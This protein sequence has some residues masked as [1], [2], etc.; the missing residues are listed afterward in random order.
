MDGPREGYFNSPTHADNV[1]SRWKRKR[2]EAIIFLCAVCVLGF[3][4]L[5]SLQALIGLTNRF[6]NDRDC[7][8]P[9][10]RVEI[11]SPGHLFGC[12]VGDYLWQEDRASEN[13]QNQ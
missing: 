13:W 8:N 12:W 2:N 1:A 7:L 6:D 5:F 4:L 9:I 10:R 3:F 11:V